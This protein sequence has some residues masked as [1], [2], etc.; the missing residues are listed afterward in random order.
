MLQVCFAAVFRQR[1]AR[2]DLRLDCGKRRQSG[3]GRLLSDKCARR[4]AHENQA[5]RYRAG[6]GNVECCAKGSLSVE[7]SYRQCTIRAALLLNDP[8]IRPSPGNLSSDKSAHLERRIGLRSAVLFN[9]LEMIG[10]GPFITLPLVIAAAG[11][12]LIGV[13]VGAG[14]GDCCG[15]RAGVG[16]T[17]RGVSAS[18]R[19][20]RVSARDL[21]AEARGKLAELSVCL[22][23]EFFRAA[24]DCFGMHRVIEFSGVVLAGAGVGAD[25]GVARAALCEL[26][27][28]GGVPAGDGAALSE[29]ELGYAAGMGA[30]C[31]RDGGDWRA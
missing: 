29:S 18:R 19:I 12:R 17:G 28:G 20:V 8:I 9:M 26:C 10:V 15:G 14:R 24:V 22:A 16:G 25:C 23:V 31:G 27:G 21:R 30:V 13:G 4:R 6:D 11:Y 3:G 5:R 2:C 1:Q 7:H